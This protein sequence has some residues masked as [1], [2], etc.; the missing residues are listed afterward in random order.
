[1]KIMKIAGTL[2][3]LLFLIS[4]VFAEIMPVK[5][6]ADELAIGE[7][8]MAYV[9]EKTER[10]STIRIW[11]DGSWEYVTFSLKDFFS[12]IFDPA[13][14][15]GIEPLPEIISRRAYLDQTL[16]Q[17]NALCE[18]K[19]GK[20][21]QKSGTS[22]YCYQR[23]F[24]SAT[25]CTSR[26]Y[27][28][29]VRSC[30]GTATTDPTPPP[31]DIT[32]VSG[33]VEK[34]ENMGWAIY[35]W[36]GRP[37][38][39]KNDAGTSTG[40]IFF[41]ITYANGVCS[42]TKR[43]D[44][45][46]CPSAEPITRT[47]YWC[48]TATG[49]I[50]DYTTSNE[51]TSP[52]ST[53]RPSTCTVETAPTDKLCYGCVGNERWE[54]YDSDPPGGWCDLPGWSETP[55]EC[56]LGKPQINVRNIEIITDPATAKKGDS[57]WVLIDLENVGTVPS[58]N[59]DTAFV[60]VQLF[61]GEAKRQYGR[62]AGLDARRAQL[63]MVE[64]CQ[65][66]EAGIVSA[67]Q[68]F[69]DA[70]ERSEISARVTLPTEETYLADG[71]TIAS[72]G[73]GE[74]IVLVNTYE[75][76]AQYDP[77]WFDITYP[78]V[79]F[80]CG[81][82][83][84]VGPI[85][86]GETTSEMDDCFAQGC[87]WSYTNNNCVCDTGIV[88]E[89]A[90]DCRTGQE[91]VGGTCKDIQEPEPVP[92]PVVV[93][94][95]EGCEPIEPEKCETGKLWDPSINGCVTLEEEDEPEDGKGN[96]CCMT[97]QETMDTFNNQVVATGFITGLVAQIKD[98]FSMVPGLKSFIPS[99]IKEDT[100][101]KEISATLD[102]YHYIKVDNNYYTMKPDKCSIIERQVVEFSPWCDGL[103]A[104]NPS[105]YKEGDISFVER[106]TKSSEPFKPVPMCIKEDR[107]FYTEA[108][109]A[110]VDAVLFFFTTVSA[111]RVTIE[112]MERVDGMIPGFSTKYRP[113]PDSACCDGLTPKY[114]DTI[115]ET[116]AEGA[117]IITTG[118]IE[119]ISYDVYTCELPFWDKLQQN[120][121]IRPKHL[122][123]IGIGI[124][125]LW[126]ISMLFRRR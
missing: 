40:I 34:Y 50:E 82:A 80:N 66:S 36:N 102:G 101:L 11:D 42:T 53:S 86:G 64:P 124:G 73:T 38:T 88:C 32:D 100:T 24:D 83:C 69:F 70:G 105:T 8:G 113:D 1:M 110:T 52:Y 72:S 97:T 46:V 89:T 103:T 125:A 35:Y 33:C 107:P 29:F 74:Y 95:P 58:T 76:C 92:E 9:E 119:H 60:E 114:K 78:L 12:T 116:S 99:S 15:K 45:G 39:C 109:L 93:C 91:C 54:A 16:A 26:G 123:Y 3:V 115:K 2:L 31:E 18:E 121:G 5:K 37:G 122:I 43:G 51:C 96:V 75:R 4:S 87:S 17:V 68:L 47:C 13:S 27:D 85:S 28:K 56:A 14:R 48:N 59:T 44:V 106:G 62:L 112:D 77:T 94:G 79:E 22:S 7:T 108:R 126:L 81:D 25:A 63:D 67:Y 30:D 41:E 49:E 10:G 118:S 104:E 120:T 61:G 65:P 71:D 90:N 98:V 111:G 57:I 19:E 117:L 55:M 84:A 20:I 23:P 21:Y 6:T